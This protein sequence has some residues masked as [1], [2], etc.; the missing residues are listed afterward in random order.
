M[1][2]LRREIPKKVVF[3][4]ARP[5]YMQLPAL[6]AQTGDILFIVYSPRRLEGESSRAFAVHEVA[7]HGHA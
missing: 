7:G 1:L 5:P 6:S 4:Q 2:Y 3:P